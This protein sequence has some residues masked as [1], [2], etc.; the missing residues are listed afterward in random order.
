MKDTQDLLKI[1]AY[2]NAAIAN[3]R[4]YATGHPQVARYL[5]RAYKELRRLLK[6]QPEVT[7]LIVDDHV[8]V[9]Q[10]TLVA[11]TPHLVQFADLLRSSAIERI[12]FSA[13]VSLA[14]LTQL[15]QE[16]AASDQ[17]AVRSTTGIKLG[18]VQ[19]CGTDGPDADREALSAEDK[20]MLCELEKLR[21]NSL[22]ALK[23]LYDQAKAVK[24]SVPQ[25]LEQVVQAFVQGVTHT[26]RP[27]HLLASLKSSDQYT[28]THAINVCLLTMAQAEALNLDP[29]HLYAIG[30]A[31]ALHDSGKMFV[32]DE[33]LNKP[34]K[35]S[36]EEWE[37]MRHHTI[38]GAR[39]ILR[40]KGIP[41]LTFIGA[42]EHHIRYDGT[43]Y[44]SLKGWRPH[45]VSQMIAIAD[46]FDA[47]RSQRPYQDPKPESLIVEILQ[48]ESGTAFNP[49]LV[50]N[51]L[52]LI[53][54][55][56]IN[57]ST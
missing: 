26:A 45:L 51:F 10:H 1:I 43:G 7:F 23:E 41:K 15:A 46:L 5:E 42:L 57:E 9:D 30:L 4:L 22:D 8:V 13:E 24:E 12:T 17:T 39:Y 36:E 47:M 16:L 31:A 34:G 20:Q 11:S 6:L 52:P 40:M 32:P 55:R 27:L 25:E 29:E 50:K 53:Q 33:I 14:E 19:V 37:L 35:L 54:A 38:R 49:I 56:A 2:L 48:K 28:F 44:P 21:D 18:K 3:T